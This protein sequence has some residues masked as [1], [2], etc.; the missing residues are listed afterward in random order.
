MSNL[1]LLF[2]VFSTLRKVACPVTIFASFSFAG[3]IGCKVATFL[4]N[5]KPYWSW[6]TK[7]SI[8]L[9]K[10][11]MVS[12]Y[13]PLINWGLVSLCVAAPLAAMPKAEDLWSLRIALLKFHVA[14]PEHIEK[15][16]AEISRIAKK[17]E[18]KY[19]G[20]C[21]GEEKQ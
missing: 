18:C 19:L 7:E 16:A 1:E 9:W 11:R 4:K 13:K 5:D 3:G 14:K 2:L 12:V 6:E 17:L 21:E 20:G 8:A 10:A 15:G